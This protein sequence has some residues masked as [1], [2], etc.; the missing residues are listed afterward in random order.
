MIP[1]VRKSAWK[2]WDWFA[3]SLLGVAGTLAVLAF[4]EVFVPD[5]LQW[6]FN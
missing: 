5:V 6:M 4:V 2:G 3:V 1:R